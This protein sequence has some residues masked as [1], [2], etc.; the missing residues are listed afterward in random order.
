MAE[1]QVLSKP[2]LTAAARM[3]LCAWLV[4][5]LLEVWPREHET[6][7]AAVQLAASLLGLL[8]GDLSATDSG[9][10]AHG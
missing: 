1:R 10:A 6:F 9:G 8:G 3:A 4:S 7:P 2:T 5:W